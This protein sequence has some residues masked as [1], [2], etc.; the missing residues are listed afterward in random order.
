MSPNNRA[1]DAVLFDLDGTILDTR[2]AILKS[3]QFTLAHFTGE[4]KPPEFFQRFMGIPLIEA[5]SQLIPGKAEEACEVYVR[6]NLSI[7]PEM[8]RGFPGAETTLAIL[9][10]RGVQLAVVTSKRRASALV[11]LELTGLSRFFDVMVCHGETANP[12]PHPEPILRAIELLGVSKGAVLMVGDSPW[13]IRAANSARKA[14]EDVS[15]C[16]S[17]KSAAVTYGAYPREVLE[18]ENPDF[19]I[20]TLPEILGLCF[21]G[22]SS[23]PD[24]ALTGMS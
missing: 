16:V 23:H 4:H 5:M 24:G 2:S 15:S 20:D 17:V 7:H 13:D 19:V 3:F 8:V 11:G 14:L 12:K 10:E 22:D 21:T 9:K 18:A 1:F 6:H